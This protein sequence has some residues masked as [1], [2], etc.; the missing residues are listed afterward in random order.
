[1]SLKA[2]HVFVISASIVLAV[3]FGYWSLRNYFGSRNASDLYLGGLS[4]LVALALIPY[5]AWFFKKV[6]DR[7]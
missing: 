7:S 6:K 2:V 1:M 3:F 4:L 5:I